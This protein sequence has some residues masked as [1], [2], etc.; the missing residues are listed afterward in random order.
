MLTKRRRPKIYSVLVIS[1][2][3]N[4]ESKN[5]SFEVF[6]LALQISLKASSRMRRNKAFSTPIVD[7]EGLT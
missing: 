4:T 5:L 6:Y 7:G 2:I 3:F 1:Q